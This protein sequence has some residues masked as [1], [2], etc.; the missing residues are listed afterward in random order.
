MS[1]FQ[2]ARRPRPITALNAAWSALQRVGVGRVS[3]SESSL[4]AAARRSSGLHHFGDESFREPMRR[5]LD[6]L[7][8]EARLHPLGRITMRQTLIRTLVNRLRL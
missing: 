2:H 3:L 1:A 8:S 7:E 6:A 5:M 4:I